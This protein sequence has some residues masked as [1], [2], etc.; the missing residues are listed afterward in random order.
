MI[1]LKT[2]PAAAVNV[3]VSEFEANAPRC[4]LTRSQPGQMVSRAFS[5]WMRRS[6]RMTQKRHRIAKKWGT[7]SAAL[8]LLALLLGWLLF[9]TGLEVSCTLVDAGA[10]QWRAVLRK[11]CRKQRDG[12][13]D[14][15]QTTTFL[16]NFARRPSPFARKL[17]E[18]G[19]FL[20]R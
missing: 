16:F 1:T 3:A 8:V 20:G 9:P 4:E 15:L 6:R 10:D 17:R 11:P 12:R 19:G 13:S 14:S 7:R 5:I 2:G 18:F